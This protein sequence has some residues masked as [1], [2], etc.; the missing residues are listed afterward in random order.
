MNKTIILIAVLLS[1]GAVQ[2]AQLYRWVDDKGRVEWRDTPP[3]SSAKKVERRTMGGGVIE[4]SEMPFSV[5]QAARNFPLTLYVTDCGE[6]CTK[7]RAHLNRRGLP[8]NEKNP[9]AD[10]E[11]YK[12]LTGGS[13][14][15]PTLFVGREAIKGYQEAMWDTALDNAGYP[16]SVIGARP[17][18]APK[19]APTAVKTAAGKPDAM[20]ASATAPAPPAPVVPPAAR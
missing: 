3:P 8:F 5:Q 4:T 14:G 6:G 17:A 11:G 1:A 10:I 12:Q 2:A 13:L 7:A 18:S 16:R 20:P 19:P 15:V 9:E